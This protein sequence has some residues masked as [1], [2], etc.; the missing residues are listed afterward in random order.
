MSGVAGNI[1]S[2][3]VAVAQMRAVETSRPD[4]LFA[5]AIAAELVEAADIPGVSSV[6][7]QVMESVP[8]LERAY[9]AVVHRTWFLDQQVIHAVE[10]GCRQVVIV[11]AG[12]DTRAYRLDCAA[13]FFEIDF[14]N[15]FDLKEPVLAPKQPTG[16]GRAAV[17]AD[18][19]S[20][21]WP[22]ALT[23]AGFDPAVPTAWVAEGLLMYLT[24]AENTSLITAIT[25]MSASGSRLIFVTNGPGWMA[26]S[27]SAQLQQAVDSAGF[28]FKSHVD[29]PSAWVSAFGWT[30][31]TAT[32]LEQIGLDLGRLY[33]LP[34]GPPR[35]WAVCAAKA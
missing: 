24:D 17:C 32:T 2:T 9:R 4:R 34:D 33:E 20:P 10:A 22:A 16:L 28:G 13:M 27:A 35:S 23:N 7:L 30:L 15:I 12:L 6:T 19:T 5:D 21:D 29:D 1:G 25:D 3:A 31:R 26:D 11:G 18:L 8:M 14:Q